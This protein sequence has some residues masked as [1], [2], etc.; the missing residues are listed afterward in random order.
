M[1]LIGN[2]VNEWAAGQ[3]VR[4]KVALVVMS[5]AYRLVEKIDVRAVP[6]MPGLAF[7]FETG[8]GLVVN[9]TGN[10]SH[11]RGCILL[12]PNDVE[13]DRAHTDGTYH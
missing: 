10:G 13:Y 2:H 11:R 12:Y 7:T 6:K 5:W 1:R 3:P 9:E 4:L 8:R